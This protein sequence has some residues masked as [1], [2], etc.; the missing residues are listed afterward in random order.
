MGGRPGRAASASQLR[1]VPQPPGP[2]TTL[3]DTH[4]TSSAGITACVGGC[5]AAVGMWQTGLVAALPAAA[6][7]TALAA[8]DLVSRRFSLTV[9]RLASVLVI[10]GLV[11][12][13]IRDAAWDRMVGAGAIT[14][15]V[16]LTNG[17][18]LDEYTRARLRRRTARHVRG[19]CT[20]VAL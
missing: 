12:D 5:V 7:L 3:A 10:A 13:A 14:G 20:S 2:M 16:A 1:T 9:L 18:P 11:F 17:D 15:L 19:R 4:A 8:S 6:G